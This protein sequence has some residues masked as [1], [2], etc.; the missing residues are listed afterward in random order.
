MGLNSSC[1]SDNPAH[2]RPFPARR[3]I[4]AE[5]AA[6]LSRVPRIQSAELTWGREQR[7]VQ[8]RRAWDTVERGGTADRARV[9]D[10]LIEHVHY[11]LKAS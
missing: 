2:C 8:S 3:C 1:G 5:L 7:E 10:Q 4:S 9:T 11:L 6:E